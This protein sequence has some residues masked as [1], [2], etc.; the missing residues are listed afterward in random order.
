VDGVST[1]A[2]DLAPRLQAASEAIA[3]DG[4]AILGQLGRLIAIDTSFPPGDGYAA[5][6]DALETMLAQLGFSFRRVSVPKVLWHAGSGSGDGE[7]VNLIADRPSAAEPCCLYYHTDTV[8]P[9]AGWTRPPL[10]LTREGD[11]LF[12]RGTADMKGAIAATLAALRA[13]ERCGATL[14]FAPTLLF[15]TDEEGGLYPGARYLAEQ[16]LIR[17]HLLNFNGGAA[18]RI[19]AGCFGSID[20]LIRVKGRGAHSGDPGNGINA[21]EESL[22]LLNALAALKEK[23]ETR[24]SAMPSPPHFD[25]QPLRARLTIAAAHGGQKGSSL[26]ALFEVLVNRRYAPEEDFAAVR[27]EIEVTIAAAMKSSRALAVDT[28]IIG[29]LAP[30]HD[31]GGP[32]WPRWQAAVARGFGFAPE[33]FRAWGASS[34]SDMG[35][36]Q[37]AGI[38]EILLGGLI[39]PE[40]NAHAP[41]EFTTLP[42]VVAL[43]RAILFYLSADF[44][45]QQPETGSSR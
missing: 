44:S 37:Q 24:V 18:P 14:R 34:S 31:P 32:H 36:V 17:G 5:F 15:C 9:G 33:S 27:A 13:A 12:G 6:A 22:P 1:T 29:H 20:F 41:D 2:G 28:E 16:K 43:A 45:E 30:V 11:R 39:R 38:R 25:G 8:P 23:V 7:R 40:S 21:L 10:A 35:W 42:D 4:D 3:R 26:P 19:W